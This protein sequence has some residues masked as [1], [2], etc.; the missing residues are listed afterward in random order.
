[1]TACTSTRTTVKGPPERSPAAAAT[2]PCCRPARGESGRRL[3][4]S[5]GSGHPST[6]HLL[7]A[8]PAP[9]PLRIDDG[10]RRSVR[11]G[12]VQHRW[13][14][15]AAALEADL[16]DGVGQAAAAGARAV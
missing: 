15:D 4:R 13:Q 3:G 11:V 12:L 14:P 9:A 1:M 5:G 8:P 16:D 10:P 2:A 6:V 7:L